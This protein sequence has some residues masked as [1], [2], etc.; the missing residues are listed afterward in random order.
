MCGLVQQDIKKDPE[1]R[2]HTCGQQF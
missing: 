2:H 1:P